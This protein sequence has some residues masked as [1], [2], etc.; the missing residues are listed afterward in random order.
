MCF[1]LCI[2]VR[3]LRDLD[4]HGYWIRSLQLDSLI[5]IIMEMMRGK[6]DL[7]CACSCNRTLKLRDMIIKS[8]KTIRL[9]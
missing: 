1:G 2:R 9:D 6:R 4:S 8:E 5:I 3:L 7:F